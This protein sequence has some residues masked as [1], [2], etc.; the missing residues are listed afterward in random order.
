M[1]SVVLFDM[2][3]LPQLHNIM[4]ENKEQPMPST[5][6]TEHLAFDDD[7]I[8][9]SC[10]TSLGMVILQLEIFVC[11]VGKVAQFMDGLLL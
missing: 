9:V 1:F 6:P 8:L 11:M 5:I 2:Y 3:V 10:P 7:I 4:F